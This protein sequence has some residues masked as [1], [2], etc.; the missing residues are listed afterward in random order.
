MSDEA[1]YKRKVISDSIESQ[2]LNRTIDLR[3][4][5]P[6]GFNEL[7][8]YPIL[9][10]QDGQDFFMYGRIATL[11]QQLILEEGV[12]P[13]LIVGVY[14]DRSQ[15]TEEYRTNGSRNAAY[16][17]FFLDEL[18]PAIESRYPVPAFGLQ[19]ILAGDSLGGT[20][21]LDIALDQPDWFQG[22]ISLSG[23][24][25]PETQTRIR[26]TSPFPPIRLYMLVG[27]QETAVETATGY[28]NFLQLNRQTRDLLTEQQVPVVYLEKPGDHNWGF[29]QKELPDALRYFFRPSN[30]IL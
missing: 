24:F 28:Y 25:F 22:V 27:E 2:E 4:Y 7:A 13:F 20:V 8:S 26:E 6:P 12:S 5:L 29:W 9:Y 11:A 14:V 1:I 23:A 3:I 16:R 18:I 10:T 15:R 17:R 21:S 19:R 30:F